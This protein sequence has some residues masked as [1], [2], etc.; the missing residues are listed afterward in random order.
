M[1]SNKTFASGW[2]WAPGSIFTTGVLEHGGV[3]ED[4]KRTGAPVGGENGSV[5]S[6]FGRGWPMRKKFCPVTGR[7]QLRWDGVLERGQLI[8]LGSDP[9]VFVVAR[10]E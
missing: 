1:C 6:F 10:L 9:L 2:R 5:S 8:F 3:L 4:K 7:R